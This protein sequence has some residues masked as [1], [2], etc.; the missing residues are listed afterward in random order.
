MIEKTIKL[1]P[2][3]FLVRKNM[4]KSENYNSLTFHQI[5]NL[6]YNNNLFFLFNTFIMSYIFNK[7]CFSKEIFVD[8]L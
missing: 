5:K 4:H 3:V 8:W 6:W 7:C 1:L 2:F